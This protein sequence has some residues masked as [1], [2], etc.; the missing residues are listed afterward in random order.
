M[1]LLYEQVQFLPLFGIA[2][3]DVYSLHTNFVNF[4]IVVI[5]KMNNSVGGI[6]KVR[7]NNPIDS[8][9]RLGLN[10]DRPE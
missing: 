2:D 1:V 3:V 7:F 9:N 6:A 8:V 10:F 5:V 4:Y